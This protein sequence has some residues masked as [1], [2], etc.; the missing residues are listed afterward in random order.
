MLFLKFYRTRACGDGYKVRG[1]DGHRSEVK[2]DTR[3]TV[4]MGTRSAV[5]TDI[6][7][8][9]RLRVVCSH[10]ILRNNWLCD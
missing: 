2:I 6:R 5:K 9:V 8:E 7:S 10:K 3:S 4:Q 1:E